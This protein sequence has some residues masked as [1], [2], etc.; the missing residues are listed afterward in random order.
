M[1][2]VYLF[3]LVICLSF[4]Q[5]SFAQCAETTEPKVLLVGDSWAWFMNTDGT[6]NTVLKTW[7]HSNCTYVCNSTLAVNG[8]QT[9]DVIKAASEAE[10]LNQLNLNPSIKAV[11]LSIGG[12]DFLGG[13]DT[14][15]TQ[16]QTD[17]L[18]AQVFYRLDSIVRYIRSCRPGIKILWSGYCYTDFREVITNFI[19]P[20]SHPFYNTW[21]GMKFPDFIQINTLQ[22]YFSQRFA[23]YAAT[24][25]DVFYYNANSLMQY[26]FGQ[27]SPLQGGIS[28]TGTYAVHQ[29]SIP[30]GFP[31]YP[32]PMVSM[33]DYGITKDCF[34]L[35]PAGYR[36][37]ISY[38]TQKFYHKLLMDDLY[39]LADS[40]Q[41]GTVS[42]QGNVSSS[43]YLGES[44]GEQFSTVLSFNTTTMADTTLKAA[45]IFLR[46]NNLT[47]S[48]PVSSSI[49]I[50]MKS[51]NF[52][53]SAAVEATDYSASGDAT[54]NPCV[55]GSYANDGDWVRFDLPASF[56]PH[57]N[58]NAITQFIISAPGFTGGK[59]NYND[60]SDP[61]FA[62]VLNLAYGQTPSGIKETN[63]VQ[64]SVY[65]NPANG[66]LTIEK[67][68]ETI[69]H[70]EITN[71]L[72]ATVLVPPVVQNTINI[73]SLP[74]GIYMLNVTTQNGKGTQRFVKE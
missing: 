43:L 16:A 3:C 22:N 35:S 12:N 64:F 21:S 66:L 49:E 2:K 37:L 32:S 40:A 4:T 38:H 23:D 50:K 65:P 26:E 69:T 55:F 36:Y 57:I 71:L 1:K 34:H 29:A 11:H 67:A 70:V 5:K 31:D 52:G 14:T 60:S 53:T 62:P 48:S 54:G 17:T 28:P 46:R 20:T 41:T 27:T 13:W 58:R 73:T 74:T 9:D 51:G 59:A 33:R 68:N 61:D 19:A 45:S 42:S 44:S 7:G 30:V 56:L 39:L 47:G 10:I 8:A 15:F 25:P 63:S 6:F 18:A 24:Q 72:G